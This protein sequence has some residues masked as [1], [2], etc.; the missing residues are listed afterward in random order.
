MQK[1][2]GVNL[3]GNAY[4]IEEA[5][6]A[7][8]RAYLERAETRLANNPDRGEIVADLEQAIADKCAARLAAHKTVVTALEID[9]I[10]AE[11]GPVDAGDATAGEAQ[12]ADGDAA[13]EAPNATTA[14]PKRL[15]QIR[16][17][18]MISGVCNGIA[19]Y[20]DVDVTLVR[21]AFALLA[22]LTKGFFL[23]V[24]FALMLIIPHAETPEEQAAARGRRFTAQDLIDQAKRNYEDFRTNKDWRRHWR[25]QQRA[26]RR[27]WRYTLRGTP[28]VASAQAQHASQTAAGVATPIFGLIHAALVLALV[29]AF[30]SLAT[31][32]TLFGHLMPSGIPYW[33]GFAILLFVYQ[34][35][36]WPFYNAGRHAY[37]VN[38]GPFAWL[39]PL[40]SL[41]WLGFIGFSIWWGY[42]HIPEVHDFIQ[43]LPTMWQQAVDQLKHK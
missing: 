24:Y 33:A 41:V 40:L 20:L 37:A 31:T 16:E 38:A 27:Q 35:V 26:W 13:H 4:Q 34:A 9:R 10:L 42:H 22:L 11:M 19:A 1:V 14:S 25:L 30:M 32:H 12:A 39:S 29:F 8:L 43:A 18:A 5:G 6:Y 2:V 21:I 3:N 7:A 28:W 23:L 17:G 36:A 15:Y